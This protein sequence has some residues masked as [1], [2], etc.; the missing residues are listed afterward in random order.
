LE[1]DARQSRGF[2]AK[3]TQA[4]A[5]TAL[6]TNFV[7]PAGDVKSGLAWLQQWGK[8]VRG[9]A[10]HVVRCIFVALPIALT[11][12]AGH[13]HTL[14]FKATTIRFRPRLF[15]DFP[16]QAFWDALPQLQ[17]WVGYQNLASA[18]PDN[19]N[20]EMRLRELAERVRRWAP[21]VLMQA[22]PDVI[23]DA[24][25]ELTSAIR[26]V[27]DLAC[28][29]S[30]STVSDSFAERF[31]AAKL[32]DCMQVAEMLRDQTKLKMAMAGAIRVLC[33]P[34]LAFKLE[35]T[36]NSRG[37]LPSPSAIRRARF[38]FDCAFALYTP[39]RLVDET[40]PGKPV[41]KPFFCWLDSSPLGGRDLLI[42]HVHAMLD[43]EPASML[44][45]LKAVDALCAMAEGRAAAWAYD[46]D[47][48]GGDGGSDSDDPMISR[49]DGEGFGGDD[50]NAGRAALI[51]TLTKHVT[52]AFTYHCLVPACLGCGATK[53]ESKCAAHLHSLH[54]EFLEAARVD[55]VLA[56]CRSYTTDM[57]VELGIV[58]CAAAGFASWFSGK[59]KPSS[60][61]RDDGDEELEVA[62]RLR[63]HLWEHA[64]PIP[65]MLHTLDNLT[66]QMHEFMT[67]W[68]TFIL[69]LKAIMSI[70]CQSG[71]LERFTQSLRAEHAW[72]VHHFERTFPAHAE[73]RWGSLMQTFDW[74][75]PLE[76]ILK[77]CWSPQ[78]FLNV[79][80]AT[81]QDDVSAAAVT[82]AI[83]SPLFW[84]YANMLSNL[85]EIIERL[86][87]WLESCPCHP[88]PDFA[89][90]QRQ[91]RQRLSKQWHHRQFKM[92]MR[93]SYTKCIFRHCP[94]KG[95]WAPHLA[96]GILAQKVS[97][98]FARALAGIPQL[99]GGLS[100]LDRAILMSDW[101][102]GRDQI[103]YLLK[104]K[105]AFWSLVPWRLCGLLHPDRDQ[106]REAAQAFSDC[107]RSI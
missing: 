46:E 12:S 72:A 67:W 86:V 96:Q 38:A 104:A 75:L 40:V 31:G 15:T 59:A 82:A 28:T 106:V 73:W 35:A 94:L 17:Q 64:I 41:C 50:G 101:A 91:E 23:A 81:G 57:G 10:N 97:M 21:Q 14:M 102:V 90:H 55:A 83:R 98:L 5:T 85:Q 68:D 88:R 93:E 100:E 103:N 43:S 89:T 2:L 95:K 3:L 78:A 48:V 34:S 39:S 66:S 24:R 22:D 70:L 16:T 51:A 56:A 107:V 45:T 52:Q 7:S 19:P 84:A 69:H 58:D 54:M 92:L 36:L 99:C 25:L 37:G 74:L 63:T 53:L 80:A 65:G 105:T 1:F 71:P 26:F 60:M 20:V 42:G 11:A 49:D 13:W 77:G 18:G 9:P 79:R 32:I 47:G 33:P 8:A 27:E 6:A 62:P 4:C 29:L 30:V 87:W 76:V 61:E 44:K